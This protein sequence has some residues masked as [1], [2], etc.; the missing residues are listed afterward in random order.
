M[1]KL[2]LS[3]IASFFVFGSA[4]AQTGKGHKYVGGSFYFNYDKN[5]TTTNYSFDTGTTVYTQ[6]DMVSLNIAP[7]FGFFLS[8]KWAIGIQPGYTRTSGTE[9]S[10]FYSDVNSAQN[11]TYANDYHTDYVGLA[12][13]LRYYW[14]LSEKVGIFPQFGISSSH[15]LNDFT[16]GGL[17]IGGSPNV[18][19]FPTPKLGINMGFGNASYYY[20][21]RSGNTIVNLSL[22]NSFN[23]GLNYYW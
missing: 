6:K 22:S 10:S 18:V 12:I 5:G 17:T 8:D 2:L 20:N 16:N 23:F 7:E 14:M 11:Y 1:N 4:L 9:I 13:N 3:L 19:F 15:I 21:Y